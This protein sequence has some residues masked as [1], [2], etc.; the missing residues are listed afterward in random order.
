[1]ASVRRRLVSELGS[2]FS[3]SCSNGPVMPAPADR[4]CDPDRLPPL[5]R[6]APREAER[7][8]SQPYGDRRA[9]QDKH[10]TAHTHTD[11]R[12]HT[13]GVCAYVGGED[14]D[15]QTENELE[16]DLS[17]SRLPDKKSIQTSRSHWTRSISALTKC[18][19]VPELSVLSITLSHTMPYYV[20]S[21][22]M[23]MKIRSMKIRS[24][25]CKKLL[26]FFLRLWTR[27]WC[28][29]RIIRLEI[30]DHVAGAL[31]T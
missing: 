23:C 10:T 31:L 3:I 2:V 6:W 30:K 1:M 19:I 4:C 11:A 25:S 27:T 7:S 16:S 28:V 24:R 5:V 12:G 26:F 29:T 13:H 20:M 22:N 8:G 17:F 18:L 15:W 9:S 21:V 14:K